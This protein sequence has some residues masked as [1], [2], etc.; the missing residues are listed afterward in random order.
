MRR[1][2]IALAAAGLAFGFAHAAGSKSVTVSCTKDLATGDYSYSTAGWPA[3]YSIA[4]VSFVESRRDS[5]TAY[6]TCTITLHI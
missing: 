6:G 1:L 3:G 2:M 4:M 5:H